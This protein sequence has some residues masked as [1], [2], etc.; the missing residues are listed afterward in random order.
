MN[1]LI[2]QARM[3][4]SRL[5]GKVMKEISNTP[6][7][8]MLINRISKSKYVDD[9]IVATTLKS[10]D[11]LIADYCKKKMITH[12]RGSDWDVLDRFYNAANSFEEP[13]ENI[14]RICSDNPLL[15]F[16]VIDFVINEFNHSGKDYFSNS[17][18]D[19][20][21]LED[22]FDVEVFSFKVLELAWK[23]AKLLSER[24]HVCPYIKKNFSC[25]WKKTNINYN[26]KLSVDTQEDFNLVSQIFD[27]L[28]HNEDFSV[29]EV[30]QLINKKPYLLDINKESRI[31]SGYLKSLKND[32]EIGE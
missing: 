24:E 10:E 28:G 17:N 6:L 16:K 1:L 22:G 2:I 32:K 8:Q 25:G 23:N 3:G 27:E 9:I 18:H 12:Y 13:P 15:S 31:N 5:P 7:L 11:D 26:Y 21:Y 30:V 19:P 29:E 14:I 20:D 4:S